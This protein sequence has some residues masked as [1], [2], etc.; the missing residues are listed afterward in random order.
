MALAPIRGVQRN[1]TAIYKVIAHLPSN[2]AHL[3]YRIRNN[4]EAFE[5]VVSENELV[6]PGAAKA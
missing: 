5:R 3:Q 1:E 6:A 4:G 2:G